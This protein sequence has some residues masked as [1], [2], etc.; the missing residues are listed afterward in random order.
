MDFAFVG[1]QP[2]GIRRG[3]SLQT[4]LSLGDASEA[5]LIPN[6]TFY[7]DTGGNWIFVL[8]PDGSEAVRRNVR[9][10]RRNADFIEVIDGLTPGEKVVLSSYSG[11]REMD[12]LTMN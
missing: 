1:E 11:Y 8:T 9:L 5:L 4:R 3:Q 2:E 7:Q 12:R 6:G 10:G